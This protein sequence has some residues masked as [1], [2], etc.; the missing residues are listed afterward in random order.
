[1]NGL[2]RADTA[3]KSRRVY[4]YV[5]VGLVNESAGN[6]EVTQLWATA[7]LCYKHVIVPG[8]TASDHN[9]N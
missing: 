7:M 8:R 9:E 3:R 4:M 2:L 5:T 1:M 6:D